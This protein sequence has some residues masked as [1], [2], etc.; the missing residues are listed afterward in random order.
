MFIDHTRCST[1]GRTPLDEWSARRR[2]LYLTTRH[3]QQTNIHAPG[4]I[5][6]HDLSRWAAA[7]RCY[8]CHGN[9]PP[10]PCQ[11]S[12]QMLSSPSPT[13]DSCSHVSSSDPTTNANTEWKG[14]E[15]QC[16]INVRMV[17]IYTH[18]FQLYYTRDLY[19]LWFPDVC[20]NIHLE[21]VHLFKGMPLHYIKPDK[22]GSACVTFLK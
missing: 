20:L 2:D 16:I 22:H 1:V 5:R 17:L 13:T 10:A 6:T 3:S 15:K 4:W 12:A 19:I 11:S 9:V 8:S 14:R 7:G 18:K 21:Q